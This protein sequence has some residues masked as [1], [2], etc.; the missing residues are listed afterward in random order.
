MF[1][2][3]TPWG[4]IV[5]VA[6]IV[7]GGAF[8]VLR[9]TGRPGYSWAYALLVLGLASAALGVIATVAFVWA[10]ILLLIGIAVFVS[11]LRRSRT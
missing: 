3:M 2:G 11:T 4:P 8:L 10:A 5:F 6:V 1:K 9:L 7:F